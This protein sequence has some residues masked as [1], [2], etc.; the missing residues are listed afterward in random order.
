MTT[1]DLIINNHNAKEELN[2]MTTEY[3]IENMLKENAGEHP[4]DT[5]GAYGRHWQRNQG[6]DFSK[7]PEVEVDC[8]WMDEGDRIDFTVSL[9]HFLINNLT[10]DELTDEFNSRFDAMDDWDGYGCGLSIDAS[11]WL[12]DCFDLNGSDLSDGWYNSYNGESNLSQVIQFRYIGNSYVIL[13]VHNGCDVRGGYTD[14]KLFRVQGDGLC[15]GVY[16]VITYPDGR[17]V[18]VDSMYNGYCLTT[19]MGEEVLYEKGMIIDLYQIVP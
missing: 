16:G 8:K 10:S 6:V 7:Q 18:D 17:G 19:E 12:S 5:G 1:K 4:L 3:I 11:K 2:R 9:Y 14:A 15:E 13:Q